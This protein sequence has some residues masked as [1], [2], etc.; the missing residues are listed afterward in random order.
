MST[1]QL[2]ALPLRSYAQNRLEEIIP[3]FEARQIFGN[4]EMILPANQAFL[5]DLQVSLGGTAG[6]EH[7][8]SVTLRHV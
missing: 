5:K 1:L 6:K 7:W 8:A 2:Y 3:A 4:I